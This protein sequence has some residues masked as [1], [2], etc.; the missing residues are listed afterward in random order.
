[1]TWEQKLAALNA[2]TQHSLIMRKPGDWYVSSSMNIGGRGVLVGVFGNGATPDEAVDDHWRQFVDEID[3]EGDYIVVDDSA[4]PKCVRWNGFMWA[5]C[6]HLRDRQ[7][8]K[9]G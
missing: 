3:K 5:D 2:I 8:A 9:V 1:M 7:M 6:S 4:F